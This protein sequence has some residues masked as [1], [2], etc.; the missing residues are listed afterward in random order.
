MIINH[1][2]RH[3]T[4]LDKLCLELDYALR[5]LA[6]NP[7]TTQRAYPAAKMDEPILTASEQRHAAGLMRI[8]HAGEVSAQALYQGQRLSSHTPAI[9]DK[10]H[11]ASLEEGDH[12]AWCQRR[13][14]EFGSHTSYLNPLWYT[15]SLL[16]GLTAGMIGDQWNLGFLAETEQQVVQHLEE[17]LRK[18]PVNDQKSLV[19]LRQMQI[20]EA[21]HRDDA[22]AAGAAPLPGL[23]KTGMQWMSKI[24]VKTTYWI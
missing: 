16:I 23:I 3:Y 4:W 20:D 17:H 10:M 14:N 12:L 13:L 6:N 21:K 19:I 24:M 18:M 1:S 22:N 8:N 5:T 7:K 11:Q 15:G 9:Q 2:I